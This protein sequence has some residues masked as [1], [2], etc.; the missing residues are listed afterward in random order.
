MG[1]GHD[2]TM[3]GLDDELRGLCARPAAAGET[4]HSRS[5][6][7]SRAALGKFFR[8]FWHPLALF[9]ARA[10]AGLTLAVLAYC[11]ASALNA[12]ATYNSETRLFEYRHYVGWLPHS[13]DRHR[14]WF[15][16]W[17]YLGLAGSFWAI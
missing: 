9:L 3:V 7:V 8:A 4:I 10:L 12:S 2:S 5:E 16:F 15:T 6:G 13:F 1:L 11:L 14:T 17:T